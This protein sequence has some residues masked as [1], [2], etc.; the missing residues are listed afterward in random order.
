MLVD[1]NNGSLPW[2]GQD[3]RDKTAE[4]K[5]HLIENEYMHVS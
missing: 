5:E 3:T 2:F 1:L 4:L